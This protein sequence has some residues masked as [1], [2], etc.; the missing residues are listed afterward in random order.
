[1]KYRKFFGLLLV[2]LSVGLIWGCSKDKPSE[3]EDEAPQ[4][5][6][7]TISVPPSLQQSS[8]PM[9]KMA[10]NYVNT[11]NMMSNFASFFTPPGLLKTS[12]MVVATGWEKKWEQDGVT[13]TLT[14]TENDTGYQWVVKLDGTSQTEGITYNNFTFLKIEQNK[15]GTAGKFTLFDFEQNTNDK[16]MEWVWNTLPGDILDFVRTFYDNGLPDTRIKITSNPDKSGE[17]FFYEYVN[18]QFV[19]YF[20]VVWT[21]SGSGQWW[22]YDNL[23][24][25]TDQGSW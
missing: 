22:T 15:D 24:N 3:P 21:A 8:D 19:L 16:F 6:P 11:A 10:M 12:D 18:G 25:I 7:K 4:F 17:L 5:V 13:V 9:A 23:G 1:M 14:A 2:L 20:H